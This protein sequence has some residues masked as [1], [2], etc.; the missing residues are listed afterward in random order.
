VTATLSAIG[1]NITANYLSLTATLAAIDSD[2]LA[3]FTSVSAT[4][5]LINS[6]LLSNFTT[7]TATLAAIGSNVTSNYLSIVAQLSLIDSNL[8]SNFTSITATLSAIGTNVTTNYLSVAATLS[9]IDSNLFSNFTAITATLTAIGTNVTT[10]YLS[11]AA[12]LVAI[13]SSLL[14][15]F[16]S[17]SAELLLIDSNLFSNFTTVMASISSTN[18][19]I[20]AQVLSVLSYAIDTN[21]AVDLV[22]DPD[23]F[24]LMFADMS[25][26]DEW[27]HIY[28]MSSHHNGTVSIYEDNILAS[29]PM[30]EI[31]VPILYPLT[32]TAGT[33]NLS[34]KVESGVNTKW[35]NTSYTV[36]EVGITIEPI[37]F[38]GV[39]DDFTQ[40]QIAFLID[41]ASN[42][43]I[44]ESSASYAESDTWTGSVVKGWNNIAWDKISV[45]DAQANFSI[46]F[47]SGSLTA[48]VNGS[49]AVPQTTFYVVFWT[50][51][52]PE[53]SDTVTV[54]GRI[55]KIA[56]YTLY[57][58]GSEII[59]G[60][61]SSLDF[62]VVFTRTGDPGAW[63]S[64][65]IKFTNGSQTCWTNGTYYYWQY[66][67]DREEQGGNADFPDWRTS[68]KFWV[69]F[70]VL[71][72]IVGIG[73]IYF[74]LGEKE[75]RFIQQ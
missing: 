22:L 59:N 38:F 34:V 17:V 25:L 63:Y 40:M 44:Y 49:Y 23:S 45:A 73:A 18:S 27:A 54:N 51:N 64:F 42:Y 6:N 29:S 10:N 26:S 71:A 13:D 15:N 20:H 9:L 11:L 68:E 31:T 46:K 8:L 56:S 35:F 12:T 72:I 37:T 2:L 69:M 75:R 62:E 39:G 61:I 53:P 55:T 66:S 60:T 36:V 4:L 30:S 67:P 28:V 33:H 57:I 74:R 48:W 47:S 14:S 70:G 52:G 19:T 50:H 7:V 24:N 58:N 3:N 1:T 65:G 41:H 16:T 5:S 21:Q 32:T 43:T